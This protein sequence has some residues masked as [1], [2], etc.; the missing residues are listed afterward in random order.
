MIFIIKQDQKV[1]SGVHFK[2][3]SGR[4]EKGIRCEAC[5][6][7]CQKVRREDRAQSIG[8]NRK[9]GNLLSD[10]GELPWKADPKIQ[11]R[12]AVRHNRRKQMYLYRGPAVVLT[13]GS[14]LLGGRAEL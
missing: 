12:C 7:H 1:L 2:E 9:S 5:R 4:A 8:E 13:F 11:D 3:M 10:K 6:S 14:F